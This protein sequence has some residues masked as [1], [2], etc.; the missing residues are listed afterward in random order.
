MTW[1]VVV[2]NRHTHAQSCQLARAVN[3]HS[4]INTLSSC[5]YVIA[6]EVQHVKGV[7]GGTVSLSCHVDTANCGEVYFI[8]W[9]KHVKEDSWTRIYLYTG[10][11]VEK[12]LRDLAGR[13]EFTI[14]PD[15]AKLT[16]EQLRLSD[17]SLYKCDVT[18]VQGKCPSLT[19]IQLNILGKPL[20]TLDPT[21]LELDLW[22]SRT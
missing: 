8:T 1:C 3:R 21:T 5:L 18:Y 15:G 11:A 17:E 19:F 6:G 7:V 10:D 16:I 9:T 22:L 2:T 4:L 14:N 13:A 20:T 12:P